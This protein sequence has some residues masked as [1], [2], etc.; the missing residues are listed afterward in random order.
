MILCSPPGSSVR[1]ISQ[2]RI[3]GWLLF[4]SP[5]NLPNPG[6]KSVSPALWADSLLLSDKGIKA[7]F[8]QFTHVLTLSLFE[9]PDFFP[10]RFDLF[11]KAHFRL[12]F[13]DG[14]HPPL[15]CLKISF[16]L[17]I[18]FRDISAAYIIQTGLLFSID[19]IKLLLHYCCSFV[20]DKPAI[21]F[22]WKCKLYK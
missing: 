3:L 6:I 16:I 9:I 2:A 11:Q 20:A 14:K 1:G 4:P 5:G 22:Q 15:T 19:G 8:F 21:H 17:P 13:S 7:L 10:S 18:F 12:F